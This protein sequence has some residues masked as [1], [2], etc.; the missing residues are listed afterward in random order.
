MDF[1]L[2]LGITAILYILPIF[3]SIHVIQEFKLYVVN[4]TAL[5]MPI[6]N[7]FEMVGYLGEAV[8]KISK[9][10]RKGND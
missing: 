3:I 1:A 6:I 7:I 9:E 4:G 2:I 5:F 8:E 10:A